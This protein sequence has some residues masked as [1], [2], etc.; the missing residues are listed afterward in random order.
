[1]LT[2]K[3]KSSSQW[4]TLLVR[5]PPRLCLS[6]PYLPFVGFVDTKVIQTPGH[7]VKGTGQKAR[8]ECIPQNGHPVVYWYQQI[9]KEGFKF[10]I[11]FQNQEALDQ[12]ETVKERFY[13][14]C[15]PKSPCSLEIKSSEPGDSALYFCASSPS[16]VLKCQFLLVH[17]LIMDP[18]QEAGDE[19]G[20]TK[21]TEVNWS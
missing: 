20:W 2:T 4:A 9:Q 7:L 17:K 5:V 10:L 12:I 8:M 18:A 19:L 1:M 16:T 14:S 3:E 11:Y 15:P 13:A 6:L 21:L